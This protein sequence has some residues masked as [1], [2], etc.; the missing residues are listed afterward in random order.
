MTAQKYLAWMHAKWGALDDTQLA[1]QCT[2][3]SVEMKRQFPELLLM[4]GTIVTECGQ[5]YV[6]TWLQTPGE[7]TTIL[8]PTERQ[9]PSLVAEYDASDWDSSEPGVDAKVNDLL[10]L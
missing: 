5:S 6:H 8:D 4:S 10:G 2:R 7:G 3:F 1:C 9:F